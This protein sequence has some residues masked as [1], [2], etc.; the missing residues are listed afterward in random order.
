MIGIACIAEVA[1]LIGDPA[2][3]NMLFA[4]R[5]DERIS[6]GDLSAIAGIAPSTASEHLA[7]LTEAGLI[8]MT[9]QGRRRYYSLADPAVAEVLAGVE[10]LAS[11]LSKRKPQPLPWDQAMIHARCCLDHLAGRLGAQLAGAIMAKGFIRHSSSGPDL[12]DEGAAWLALLNI[13]VGALRAEPRRFL[14][15]CPDW[16]EES[17]HIGGAVGGAMLRGLVDLGWLRRVHGS[18]KVL[19]TPKGVSGFRSQLD[20]DVRASDA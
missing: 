4:L 19:V 1:S 18:R 20:L 14:R 7:K 5:D 9:A 2:R 11:T 8:R 17:L 16:I 15:L 6:A 10:G 12:T 3:A 13:D